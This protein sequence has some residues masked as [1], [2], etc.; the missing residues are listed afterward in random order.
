MRTIT[1]PASIIFF[2]LFILSSCSKDE[3]IKT[4]PPPPGD[5]NSGTIPPP[6]VEKSSVHF[7]ANADL[8]GQPYHSS[9]LRA[10]VSIVN[11]KGEEVAKD[12]L[13]TLSLPNPVKTQSL[14]LPVG[15]YKLTSFRMEYGS[16]QTHFVTPVAGSAKASLVQHPLALDFKVEK[17]APNEINVEVVRVQQGEKPQQFGYPSGAFDYGQQD[18]N[19]YMKVRIKA[20]MR[21]GDI[22]Y[23]SVPASLIISTW[24]SKGE[25]STTYGQLAA[26]VNEVQ[27]LK[28]AVK[29]EFNVSKWGTN[30]AMTLDRA[31]VDENTIY[32]LGGYRQAKKLKSERVYK[33][34]NGVDVPESKTDYFYD[35]SGKL[36]RIDYWLK[37][38]DNTS[39]LAMSDAFEYTGGRASRVVRTTEDIETVLTVTSF[40][41]DN[42]GKVTTIAQKDNGFETKA[43]VA[44]LHSPGPQIAIHYTYPGK[45]VDMN[46]TMSFTGGNMTASTAAT[47]YGTTESGSYRY[48]FN[49]NPYVHMKWPNLFL[50]N[51]S[52]NNVT[53]QYKYYVGSSPVADPYSFVYTYD[54]DGYPTQVIKNFK[55]PYTGNYLFS[56]KTVFVY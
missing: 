52:I 19:P 41:Y 3:I 24:N 14:E 10:S 50:S 44:Y 51:N 47:A 33:L 35:A 55:S 8:T 56:T 16:V 42:S 48:D 25:M 38:K 20:I 18:A 29:Y 34:V 5:G 9:N 27:V 4:P 31:D 37:K 1:K 15:N 2:L 45:A 53:A 32:T 21:I 28:A 46:Y 23:D 6:A 43:T 12:K 49:I 17:N 7:I 40:G 11:E 54:A 26:G 36:S 22:V 13:L 39:Y 30:D